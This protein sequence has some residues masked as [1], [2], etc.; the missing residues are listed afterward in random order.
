MSDDDVNALMD[1]DLELVVEL[2]RSVSGRVYVGRG[3]KEE[4]DR[5]KTERDT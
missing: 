5:R 1:T 4:K 3:G 2:K